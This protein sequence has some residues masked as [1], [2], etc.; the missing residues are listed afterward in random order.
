LARKFARGFFELAPELVVTFLSSR[1]ADD[2]DG[3]RQIAIGSK[4]VKRRDEFALGEIAC[5]AENHNT[6]WLW[7]AARRQTLA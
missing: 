1:E 5:R 7:H 6:A 3:G 4:V 2:C